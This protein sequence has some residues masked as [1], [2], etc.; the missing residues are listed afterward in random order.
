MA[1]GTGTM[2][3]YPYADFVNTFCL[4]EYADLFLFRGELQR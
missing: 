3:Y 1:A 2:E 4:G